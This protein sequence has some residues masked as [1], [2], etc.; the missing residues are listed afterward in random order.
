MSG[1]ENEDFEKEI[2]NA[3][4][5]IDNIIVK[6]ILGYLKYGK[7][8]NKTA[9]AYITAYTIVYKLADDEH[10]SSLKLFNY[11]NNTIKKY[12][13]EICSSL[14]SEEDALFLDSFLK[15]T[16]KTKIL[17]HWM[18]KVFCYLDQFYTSNSKVGTLFENG[19]KSYFSNLFSPLK[20][21]IFTSLNELINDHR[22]CKDVEITK[23]VKVI[24][25]L[26]QVDLKTPVLNLVEDNFEWT[27]N[28]Q[29]NQKG[30]LNEWFF[31]HFLISTESY[32]SAKS[33]REIKSYSAPEY[34][35][36]CLKY[37]LEEDDRKSM[38][39][40]KEFYHYLD[41]VNN[42]FLIEN[43]CSLLASMDTGIV[44]MFKN[45]EVVQLNDLYKLFSRNVETFKT[46]TDIMSPYIKDRGEVIYNNK[47]LARDPTSK[48]NLN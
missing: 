16:E 19:M 26:K 48:K 23:I 47:D 15:E 28:I 43:N 37:V 1:S 39:L 24:K 41:G 14:Q 38:F 5:E 12:M 7:F 9:T 32:I 11:Y 17:I 22:D 36:S 33:S 3:I 18:R 21:R 31:N 2:E 44:A 10:D 27:G 20:M 29:K 45:R 42:K 8:N 6:N 25:I 40:N 34:I 13:C 4:I 46:I 35:K 30:I